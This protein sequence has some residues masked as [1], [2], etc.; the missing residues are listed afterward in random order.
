MYAGQMNSVR[1]LKRAGRRR[2]RR[3]VVL[4]VYAGRPKGVVITP[5]MVAEILSR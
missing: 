5:E 1:R 3:R 4:P 2:S